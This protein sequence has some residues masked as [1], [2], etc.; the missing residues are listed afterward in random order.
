[1]TGR[2]SALPPSLGRVFTRAAAVR[3][4][5]SSRRLQYEDLE[6]IAHGVYRRRAATNQADEHTAHPAE[7]WRQRQCALAEDLREHL[8]P[9]SFLVGAS[10]AALWGLPVP[11]P[12]TSRRNPASHDYLEI[13][14]PTDAGRRPPKRPGFHARQVNP[15]LVQ[16]TSIRGIP[17]TTPAVTWAMLVPRL[18]FA[19]GVALG[20]AIIHEA[21]VPGTTRLRRPPLASLAEMHAAVE[22]GRRQGVGPLR[23]MLPLLSPHS[24]SVPESHLRLKLLEWAAPEFSLDHDVY[25]G[26]GQLVGC[27][28]IAF[29]KFRLALEYEGGHHLTDPKQWNRDI[30]KYQHYVQLGWEPL[31]V[32]SQL[33]YVRHGELRHQVFEALRRRGWRG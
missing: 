11:T 31:R 15:S 8:P 20:D 27:S 29:P 10:A 26:G 19:D 33:L 21:R 12:L 18:G 23:Q 2:P 17:L 32:T 22:M 30:E 28:E 9:H 3:E 25:D 24:A 16:A 7:R 1:M 13:A 4:G 5:V 14:L 6:R